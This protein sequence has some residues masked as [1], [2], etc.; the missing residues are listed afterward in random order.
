MRFAVQMLPLA[1]RRVT[2][3]GVKADDA[4]HLSA[5]AIHYIYT[6]TAG[7]AHRQNR[8][9][10]HSNYRHFNPVSN[11]AHIACLSSLYCEPKE[12]LLQRNI[13]LIAKPG[14]WR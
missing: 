10:L 3:I 13:A 6:A 7:D 4:K 14:E 2:R 11:S 1:H 12:A 8:M 5:R 9:M